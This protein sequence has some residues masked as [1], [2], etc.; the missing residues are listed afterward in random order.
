MRFYS[1]GILWA[2]W[3]STQNEVAAAVWSVHG[4]VAK[5]CSHVLV[6]KS[7]TAWIWK[8]CFCFLLK[9]KIKKIPA[10]SEANNVR[11]LLLPEWQLSGLGETNSKTWNLVVS[12]LRK[13]HGM[14][15]VQ[16]MYFQVLVM[17][18]QWQPMKE[19]MAWKEN[20][21]FFVWIKYKNWG[22][23]T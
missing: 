16:S 9:R 6:K 18:C 8:I 15:T 5:A 23:K 20:L 19:E 17:L 2:V 22:K 21:Q 11:F 1:S 3:Y 14:R 10:T 13:W 7:W 12:R 4:L